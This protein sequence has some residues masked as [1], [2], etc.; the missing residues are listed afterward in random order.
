MSTTLNIATSSANS[1]F[2]SDAGYLYTTGITMPTGNNQ[3]DSTTL[4]PIRVYSIVAEGQSGG[5]GIYQS[6]RYGS[7]TTTGNYTFPDSG[8]TFEFRVGQTNGGT[9]MYFGR[10]TTY[11]GRNIY[12]SGDGSTWYSGQSL[13]GSFTYAFVPKAPASLA[14][15]QTGNSVALTATA[16]TGTGFDGYATISAYKVQYRTSSDGTTWGAW[17]NTQT[18]SSLSYTYSNLAPATHYQFRVYAVNEVGNGAATANAT[19]FFVSAG[20]KRYNGTAFVY[21]TTAKR[22]NGSAWVDLTVAKRWDGSAW[23]DLT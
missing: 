22:W 6:I 4:Q 12:W 5:S 10:D 23:K 3:L 7:V 21:N 20:G 1:G 2:F 11:S 15:V 18:M 16:T 9:T 14:A 17:G 8:G 13:A 19:T